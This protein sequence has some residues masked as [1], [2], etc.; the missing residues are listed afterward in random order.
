M[1]HPVLKSAKDNAHPEF[2]D[3]MPIASKRYAWLIQNIH[4]IAKVIKMI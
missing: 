1:Q 3:Q 4:I 2:P